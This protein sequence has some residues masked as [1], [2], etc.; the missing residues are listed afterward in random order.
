M[1]SE[2]DES[3]KQQQQQQQQTEAEMEAEYQQIMKN[4]FWNEDPNERYHAKGDGHVGGLNYFKPTRIAV[5]FNTNPADD[6]T[7]EDGPCVIHIRADCLHHPEFWFE[8]VIPREFIER[9]VL[10]KYLHNKK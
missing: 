4:D 3:E 5:E 8:C 1:A 10:P 2:Y 9:S 6:I 7:D